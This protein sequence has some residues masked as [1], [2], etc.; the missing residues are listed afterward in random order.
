MELIGRIAFRVFV[1]TSLG[2][3]AVAWLMTGRLAA[4]PRWSRGFASQWL[5]SLVLVPATAA[6]GLGFMTALFLLGPGLRPTLA[7]VALGILAISVM[8]IVGAL[9]LPT[10]RRLAEVG[11]W[12]L[13][14]GLACLALGPVIASLWLGPENLVQRLLASLR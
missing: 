12:L 1:L 13:S 4:G 3:V 8:A 11:L 2:F 6:V 10:R 14:V 5:L 7:V 9:G